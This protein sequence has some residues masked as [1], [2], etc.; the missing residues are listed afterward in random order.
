M[1]KKIIL[2]QIVFPI[3][4]KA[5][6]EIL[7]PD[8]FKKY[9]DRVFDLLEDVIKDSETKID[10]RLLPLIEHARGLLGI[11]DLPDDA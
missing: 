3:F 7:S 2:D 8:N 4:V 10:D 5:A 11:P 9:G 1:F 6:K